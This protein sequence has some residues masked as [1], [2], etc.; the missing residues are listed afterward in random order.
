MAMK[1]WEA[2]GGAVSGQ[3]R[4]WVRAWSFWDHGVSSIVFFIERSW[5]HQMRIRDGDWKYCWEKASRLGAYWAYVI[6]GSYWAY[7]PIIFGLNDL[8]S[9]FCLGLSQ[10]WIRRR[11]GQATDF[12]TNHSPQTNFYVKLW[13]QNLDIKIKSMISHFHGFLFGKMTPSYFKRKRTP[14]LV[15]SNSRGD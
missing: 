14:W 3:S 7:D 11:R 9:V 13:D 10:F 15:T 2:R 12:G 6:L 8:A 1:N 5:L 4:M